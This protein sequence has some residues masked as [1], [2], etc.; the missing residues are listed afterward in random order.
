M[1]ATTSTNISLKRIAHNSILLYVRLGMTMIFSLI[2]VRYLLK[3]LQVEDYGIYNAI[4]GVVTSLALV[5]GVMA[6]ASQ[7]YFSFSLGRHDI[8]ELNKNFN[9]LLIVY[10]MM[11][12]F[13]IIIAETV[14]L[15]FISNKLVY[16][17]EMR[18]KVFWIYQFSLCTFL[19]TLS[20]SPFVAL[21][22]S[23]EEMKIYS[24][25]GIIDGCMK[26]CCVLALGLFS[27]SKVVYYPLL[28]LISSILIFIGYFI[29]IRKKFIYIRIEYVWDFSRLKSILNFSSWSLLG[30]VANIFYNQ[31]INVMFNL[32]IGPIANAAFAIANQVN[33]AINSFGT[34]FFTA[35]KPGII[36]SYAQNDMVMIPKLM[37]FSS[38]LLFILLFLLAL[39][40]SIITK[41]ILQLWL[42]EITP[43]SVSFVR[44]MSLTCLIM[45][46]GLP[47]TTLAQASG[48]IKYYHIFVDGFLSMSLV[49]VYFLLKNGYTPTQSLY[50]VMAI[51]FVAHLIRIG[52]LRYYLQYSIRGYIQ[53]FL[54]PMIIISLVSYILLH[55]INKTL[56][57]HGF[58]AIVSITCI[59]TMI[60]SVLSYLVLLDKKERGV[61]I[62]FLFS[63]FLKLKLR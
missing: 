23:H 36:K 57:I 55:Y 62:K 2:S 32:F 35:V 17:E 51:T 12:I 21:I 1:P 47:I 10:A 7:R 39:P 58:C 49:G 3:E 52:Y 41:D 61:V 15:W 31:G 6:S 14:G 28:L 43:Y 24:Y 59:S 60:I 22:I 40:I 63:I 4:G 11:I 56:Q 26:L 48:K 46:L 45:C 20:Y 29:T 42:G 9:S 44:I 19:T 30:S 25:F 53:K 8:N 5:S 37:L 27:S 54:C 33:A 50:Y 18:T 16:P 38:K 34:N 13:I